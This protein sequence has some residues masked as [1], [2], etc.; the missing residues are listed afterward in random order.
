MG[1]MFQMVLWQSRRAYIIITYLFFLSRIVFNIKLK[2][3]SKMKI[4][5]M[6]RR[7]ERVSGGKRTDSEI[8]SE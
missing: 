4:K 1:K 6:W 8:N 2:K 5:D 3:S 7:R